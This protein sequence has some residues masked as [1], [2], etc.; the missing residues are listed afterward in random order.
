MGKKN[1][2]EAV[3][4]AKQ[5]IEQKEEKREQEKKVVLSKEDCVKT[6]IMMRRKLKQAFNIAAAKRGAE[7]GVLLNQ[8]LEEWLIQNGELEQ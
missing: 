2:G 4:S 7:K 5:S 1:F 6:S 8:I 3:M